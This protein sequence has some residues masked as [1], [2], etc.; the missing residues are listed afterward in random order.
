MLNEG[1]ILKWTNQSSIKKAKPF[2]KIEKILLQV[3]NGVDS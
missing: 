2:Y 1:T 3:E